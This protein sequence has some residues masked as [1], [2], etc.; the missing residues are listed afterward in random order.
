[1]CWCTVRILWHGI[2]NLKLGMGQTS[3]KSLPQWPVAVLLLSTLSWLDRVLFPLT[4]K[5]QRDLYVN[6]VT[7]FLG[8]CTAALRAGKHTYLWMCCVT[9]LASRSVVL[10]AHAEAS[11]PETASSVKWQNWIVLVKFYLTLSLKETCLMLVMSSHQFIH[12]TMTSW[13]G[14]QT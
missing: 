10:I 2:G 7:T 1:M 8:S 14:F 12:Y 11:F 3:Q 9:S 4:W 5:S 6:V 13:P